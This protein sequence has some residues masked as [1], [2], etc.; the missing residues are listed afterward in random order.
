MVGAEVVS[1]TVAAGAEARV[2]AE[3]L[4]DCHL[5]TAAAAITSSADL[6]ITAAACSAGATVRSALAAAGRHHA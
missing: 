3:E 1:R 4:A 5:A 6:R 2:A